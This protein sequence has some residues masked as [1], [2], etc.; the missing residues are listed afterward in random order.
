MSTP[1][2]GLTG[3][4]GSGKSAAAHLFAEFGAHVIDMDE[5]GRWAVEHQ[6]GVQEKIAEKFGPE[7]FDA[8]KHLQRRRLGE[9]V[10]ADP[11]ALKI[12]NEIVH[13]VM[14]QHVRDQIAEAK[15]AKTTPYI[16]IDAALIFE[17]LFDRECEATVVVT[18][19][20]ELCLQRAVDFKNLSREKA[21][22]RIRSQM[23][24]DEKAA[25]ADFIVKNDGTLEQLAKNVKTVHHLLSARLNL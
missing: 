24:Q 3:I 15:T 4:L 14:L 25:R 7:I 11:E 17:L 20:I 5:A 19:P 13:P 16:I 23:S 21:L 12:L 9:I 18:S 8:Q 6:S 22:Q 10:F 2:V 1:V